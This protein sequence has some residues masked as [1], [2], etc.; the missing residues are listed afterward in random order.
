MTQNMAQEAIDLINKA[1]CGFRS[2]FC[3][4]D[5]GVKR[6]YNLHEGEHTFGEMRR[7]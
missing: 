2:L 3:A 4:V 1:G 7:L 5:V 6:C